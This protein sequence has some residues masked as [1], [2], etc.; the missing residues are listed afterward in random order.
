M[1]REL[2]NHVFKYH[3]GRKRYV[4]LQ[5]KRSLCVIELW[6]LRLRA[7]CVKSL[8]LRNPCARDNPRNHLSGSKEGVSPLVSHV[9]VTRRLCSLCVTA[10]A[11]CL[12]ERVIL[13]LF[14]STA[15]PVLSR[16]D[17]EGGRTRE[18][19]WVRFFFPR[20]IFRPRASVFTAVKTSA[21]H[22]TRAALYKSKTKCIAVYRAVF[23][24]FP[25]DLSSVCF[26]HALGA[27]PILAFFDYRYTST[28]FFPL[29]FRRDAF[30]L[31]AKRSVLTSEKDGDTFFMVSAADRGEGGVEGGKAVST[32][33]IAAV[34]G[35]NEEGVEV[36]TEFARYSL[37]QKG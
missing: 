22:R 37:S 17:S 4:V 15:K 29:E 24:E 19:K 9:D 26:C 31:S 25:L 1:E 18:K 28:S 36:A 20:G 34:A 10:V 14:R 3:F 11:R 32:T 27:A 13:C 30:V 12:D 21:N 5:G 33:T 16:D 2:E 35:S 8:L 7:N 6:R 23:L